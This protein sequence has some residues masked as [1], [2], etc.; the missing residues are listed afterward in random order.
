MDEVALGAPP[1]QAA[2]IKD[3]MSNIEKMH[4]IDSLLKIGIEIYCWCTWSGAII[5]QNKGV[6]H[7]AD[8]STNA[9]QK[10]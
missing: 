3:S 6:A 8:F 5:D 7:D 9:S 4:F 10:V 1:P 2:R